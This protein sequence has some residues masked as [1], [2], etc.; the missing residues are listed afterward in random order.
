MKITVDVDLENN[1][2]TAE[3]YWLIIDPKQNLSMSLSVAASQITGPFFSREEA[4]N[5][6]RYRAHHYSHRARVYCHSGCD[7]SEYKRA[8]RDAERFGEG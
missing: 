5:N 4:E 7:T 2:A 6:L 1:E 8:I 3:P